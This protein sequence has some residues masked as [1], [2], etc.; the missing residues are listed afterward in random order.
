MSVGFCSLQGRSGEKP[1]V[2]QELAPGAHGSL[3]TGGGVGGSLFQEQREKLKKHRIS[4]REET[5]KE[6]DLPTVSPVTG[7][8]SVPAI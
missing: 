4:H 8:S 6:L 7:S 1:C 3:L 5:L 2:Q